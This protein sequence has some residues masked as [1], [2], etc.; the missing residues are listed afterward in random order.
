MAETPEVT[1]SCDM[2]KDCTSPVAMLEDKG[3]IYCTVHGL[4]RRASGRRVRKL[5]P[6]ELNRLKKGQ[7]IERY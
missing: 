4:M 1:P 7:Q 2:A 3:W 5:R 6:H